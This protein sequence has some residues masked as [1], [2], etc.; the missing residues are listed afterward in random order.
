MKEHYEKDIMA[1]FILNRSVL[2][3]EYICVAHISTLIYLPL[4][5]TNPDN[6]IVIYD[7]FPT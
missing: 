4:V 3:G 2:L 6:D 7:L 5:L 1:V